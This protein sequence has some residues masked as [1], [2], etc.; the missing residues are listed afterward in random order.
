MPET[1]AHLDE[2]RRLHVAGRLG[3]R[4]PGRFGLTMTSAAGSS[5]PGRWWS[6]TTTSNPAAAAAAT[7]AT[8][9]VPQSAVTTSL[10]PSSRGLGT[11]LATLRHRL[12]L[13]YG[14]AAQLRIG[15]HLPRGVCSEVE[16]P[17]R[18]GRS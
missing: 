11:G 7:A 16:Y 15:E 3:N 9:P 18:G 4:L 5:L 2:I 10:Q 13:L 8:E 14:D 6:V 17:V 1:A 12:R